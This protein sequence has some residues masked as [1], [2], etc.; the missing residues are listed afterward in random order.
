ME[1]ELIFKINRIKSVKKFNPLEFAFMAAIQ[2]FLNQH[3]SP[4]MMWRNFE[5]FLCKIKWLIVARVIIPWKLLN[6]SLSHIIPLMLLIC[7]AEQTLHYQLLLIIAS[8]LVCMDNNKSFWSIKKKI[9][10]TS[11]ILQRVHHVTTAKTFECKHQKFF[12]KLLTKI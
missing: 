1:F 2:S 7:N 3:S 5:S 11:S 6:F 4:F 8:Q 9:V 12:Q 10:K